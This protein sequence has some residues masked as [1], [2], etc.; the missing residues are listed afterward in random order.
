MA[1]EFWKTIPDVGVKA[2]VSNL[3]RI[4]VYEVDT[5]GYHIEHAIKLPSNGKRKVVVFPAGKF[6][7]HRLVADAFLD[8]TKGYNHIDF[9]DGDESNCSAINLQWVKSAP[10]ADRGWKLTDEQVEQIKKRREAGDTCITIAKDFGVCESHV[11][12]ICQ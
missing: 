11:W 7:V 3:G 6:L 1:L 9:M 5:K 4:R 10:V 2:E 8:N 12:R